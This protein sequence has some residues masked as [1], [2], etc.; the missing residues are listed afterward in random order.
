[1]KKICALLLIIIAT[2]CKDDT[3]TIEE[4]LVAPADGWVF[5]SVIT[6]D[7]FTM[8][9]KDLVR[10]PTVFKPCTLDD[11]LYFT[12]DG[13]Y[14]VRTNNKCDPSDP[15]VSDNGTWSLNDERTKLTVFSTD[16]NKA[17]LELEAFSINDTKF[18]GET[19]KVGDLAVA[20]IV[21]MRKN[22]TF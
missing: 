7:P 19:S 5:D 11:A 10:D 9:T 13:K 1:M 3:P 12:A 22:G 16:E 4:Y 17:I 14:T 20:A 18:K 21:T 6:V 8:T 15:D 2:S